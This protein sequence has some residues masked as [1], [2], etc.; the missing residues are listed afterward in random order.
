[1]AGA[2]GLVL[3]GALAGPARADEWSQIAALQR[4]KASLTQAERKLDSQ[5]AV[6]L[7]A[8]RLAA[9][10][11]PAQAVEVDIRGNVPVA[12]LRGLGAR[13]TAVT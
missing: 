8:P 13:V 11:T 7:K 9:G 6:R 12:K 4:V 2:V 3:A 5:L 10:V 1:M